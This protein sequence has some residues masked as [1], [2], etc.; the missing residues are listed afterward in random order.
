MDIKAKIEEVVGKIKNDP[1]LMEKFKKDPVK[2]VE[3][4]LGV[5]LPDD[6]V[7][8]LVTGV[9]AR[10]SGDNLSGALGSLKKLF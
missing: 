2:A 7:E 9:K 6:L 5:D 8:K 3:G 10:L 1:Q 4:V